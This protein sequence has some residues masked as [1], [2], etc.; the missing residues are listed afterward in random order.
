MIVAEIA[1][2]VIELAVD[3]TAVNVIRK[4]RVYEVAAIGYYVNPEANVMGVKE[5]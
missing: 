3:C 5:K 1:V 4:S 2:L